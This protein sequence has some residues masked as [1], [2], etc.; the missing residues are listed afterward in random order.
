[1]GGLGLRNDRI[2]AAALR[3]CCWGQVPEKPWYQLIAEWWPKAQSA[4]AVCVRV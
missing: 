4:A 1:L 2:N 3:Q